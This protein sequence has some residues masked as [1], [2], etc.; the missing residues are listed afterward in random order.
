MDWFYSDG[1][2]QFGPVNESEFD[3]LRAAGR[4]NEQ[5]LVWRAG[6]AGWEPL[7]TV[8]PA[9]EVAAVPAATADGSPAIRFCSQCGTAHPPDDL[10]ELGTTVICASCKDPFVQRLK[11]GALPGGLAHRDRE[12][13]GFWIRVGATFTDGIILWMLEMMVT[14]PI[15]FGFPALARWPLGLFSLSWFISLGMAILYESAFVVY[16]GATPG[17][18]ALSLEVIR[19]DGSRPGWG[20]AIG[21]YFAKMVSWFTMGIGFVMAGVD[22]EKRALHDRI[23]NTRVIRKRRAN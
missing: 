22:E 4:V 11:E 15:T 3:V 21:R 18:L 6:M 5:S 7:G 23:C 1:R 2:Q 14:L 19:E 10:L 16:K 9:V 17:K 13:G 8:A 12:Y 20:L